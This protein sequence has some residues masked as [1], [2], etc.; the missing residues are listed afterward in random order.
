[1]ADLQ[2]LKKLLAEEYDI[3]TA[4]ELDEAMKKIGGLNMLPAFLKEA[5]K[6]VDAHNDDEEAHHSIQNSI[7]DVSARLALL[8]LM[9][10]TSVT[11][12]PFTVT[13]ETLDGTVVEGVW[14]TTAKRIEF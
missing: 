14:N 13:F 12:N 7:S 8:E 6:L 5:Q 11:G 9:F 4:R 3:T 10:N 2:V 1:M